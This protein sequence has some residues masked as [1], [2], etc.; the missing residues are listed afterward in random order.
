MV[1]V[2]AFMEALPLQQALCLIGL[3]PTGELL[4]G[5]SLCVQCVFLAT[6][7]AAEEV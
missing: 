3:A 1:G 5:L 4:W 6:G 7:A 2:S